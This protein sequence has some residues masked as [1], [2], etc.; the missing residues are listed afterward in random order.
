MRPLLL[1]LR[2]LLRMLIMGLMLC[3]QLYQYLSVALL[4]NSQMLVLQQLLIIMRPLR[5]P[6]H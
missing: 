4:K 6:R 2:M 3:A 1:L 5:K